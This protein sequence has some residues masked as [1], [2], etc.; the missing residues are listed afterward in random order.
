MSSYK[1]NFKHVRNEKKI[2]FSAG[3]KRLHE[4]SKKTD[5]FIINLTSMN[6][7]AA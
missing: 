1:E 5:N 6:L 4:F 3:Q 2:Y 7:A